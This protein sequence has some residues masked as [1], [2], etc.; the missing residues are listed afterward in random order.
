MAEAASI[1][2]KIKWGLDKGE[3]IFAI[4]LYGIVRSKNKDYRISEIIED[5]NTFLEYGYFEY[6]VYASLDG[7]KK[8]QFF[9]QRYTKR[10]DSIEYVFPDEIQEFLV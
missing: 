6:L 7:S 4:S 5:K 10:P 2:R 1:I 8:D 3:N 9:W